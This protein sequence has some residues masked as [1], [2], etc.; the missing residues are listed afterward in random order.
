MQNYRRLTRRGFLRWTA[1][2]ASSS[3]LAAC[4]ASPPLGQADTAGEG[5]VAQS[6]EPESVTAFF[7]DGPP[8]I[9]IREE[10]LGPFSEAYPGCTMEFT[11]VPG[12]WTGGYSDKLFTMLAADQPPDLFIIPIADL[13]S[14]LARDLLLDLKP[15]IERDDYDLSE[16]P[17]LAIQS[18]THDGGIYGLPDN[19]ASYGNFYNKDMFDEAG[20]S[21]PTAQ[22]DD[23]NWTVDDFLDACDALTQRDQSGRIV[24]YAYSIPTNYRLWGAWVRIFGGQIVDDPF[25]PTECTL[26]RPEAIA[27]LQFLYDLRWTHEYA[28]RPEAMAEIGVTDLLLT[29]RLAMYDNGS[30]FFNQI[31]G[32]DFGFDVGHMPTGTGGRSNYVFYFPLVIPQATRSPDCAWDLLK[33][34]QGPAIETIIKSAGLQGTRLSAQREW[35]LGDPEPPEHKEVFVDA[36]EHFVAPDPLVTTWKEIEQMLIAE[37]DLLFLGERQ[38]A[39]TAQAIKA[40]MD[41]LIQQ[42]QWRAALNT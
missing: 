13:P 6:G 8:L 2:A 26:D 34:F 33:F 1:Y 29:Q 18:Y 21:Y 30:W 27:G 36:V 37:M 25:Y 28:P 9:G 12:G 11:S 3:V 17:D 22:W 41:P 19:V 7:W 35:F 32:A 31:R 16:F 15:F 4:V 20:L 10:A 39:E 5:D 14:F 40:Q 42:G 24:Q 23:P 38:A